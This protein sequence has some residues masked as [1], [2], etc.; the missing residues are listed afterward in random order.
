M[1]EE[2]RRYFKQQVSYPD[3]T[4][5]FDAASNRGHTS[6]LTSFNSFPIQ[7]KFLVCGIISQVSFLFSTF[8]F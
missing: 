3:V 8:K 4:V 6:P 7:F 5:R 2:D 1:D